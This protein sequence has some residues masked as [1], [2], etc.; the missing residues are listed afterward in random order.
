M[1]FPQSFRRL[2][3]EP[4]E[5]MRLARFHLRLRLDRHL[6]RYNLLLS[7]ENFQDV[8]DGALI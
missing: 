4:G 1:P 2:G 6:P 3:R 8:R 7:G 5:A